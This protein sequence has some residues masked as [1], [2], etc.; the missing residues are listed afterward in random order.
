[1]NISII[2]H[3]GHFGNEESGPKLSA[4]HHLCHNESMKTEDH[5]L[6]ALNSQLHTLV[7]AVSLCMRNRT[8]K[9]HER[10]DLREETA[11]VS[12]RL[13]EEFAGCF[14][15]EGNKTYLVNGAERTPMTADQRRD[16]I[17][18]QVRE[19]P[20]FAAPHAQLVTIEREIDALDDEINA[21][22]MRISALKLDIRSE[23]V[24]LQVGLEDQ[25]L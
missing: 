9:R 25:N 7:G 12:H 14:Q 5:D 22:Q 13:E 16:W 6:R 11:R 21:G 3:D 10:D 1:M 4:L 15:V 2:S 8:S 19:S 17:S 24:L 23:M 18:A 20:D